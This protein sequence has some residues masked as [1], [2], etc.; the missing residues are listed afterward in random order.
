MFF[1]KFIDDCQLEIWLLRG[2]VI[3]LSITMTTSIIATIVMKRK[4]KGLVIIPRGRGALKKKA[5]NIARNVREV[6]NIIEE[7]TRL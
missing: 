1:L 6:A 7:E 4:L 5:D 3:F 2:T